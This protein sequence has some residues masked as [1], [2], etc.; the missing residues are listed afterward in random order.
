M[1]K[2]LGDVLRRFRRVLVPEMNLGQL[3]HRIR[4]AYL[5]DAIGFHKVQGKPF[6]IHEVEQK[7]L[8]LTN[9]TTK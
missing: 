4:S 9:G 3:L 1:Q 6:M 5:V 7:I 2:D 8:E